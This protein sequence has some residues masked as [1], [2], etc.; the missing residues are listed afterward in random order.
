[1]TAIDELIEKLA[2]CP[3][4]GGAL[5]KKGVY[6]GPGVYEAVWFHPGVVTDTD[7]L[8]SG[9]GFYSQEL[10]AWNTRAPDPALASLLEENS[11]L[12]E[13]L[14]QIDAILLITRGNRNA[15][16]LTASIEIASK[17]AASALLSGSA[18]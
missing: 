16:A 6:T 11:R 8:L 17:L 9:R 15:D 4:C 14:G 3:F 2:P 7:C 13:A 5:K 10:E 1:M 18:K 12:K